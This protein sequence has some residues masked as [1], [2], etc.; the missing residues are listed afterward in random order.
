MISALLLGLEPARAKQPAV[1]PMWNSG[2]VAILSCIC[3]IEIRQGRGERMRR[4]AP[5]LISFGITVKLATSLL[6]L[7]LDIQILSL[8]NEVRARRSAYH[9]M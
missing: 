2:K 8:L 5:T 7:S 4:A 1:V 3:C 6:R 9:C